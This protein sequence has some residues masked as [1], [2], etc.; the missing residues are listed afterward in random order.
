MHTI[1]L[2][3]I[4]CVLCGEKAPRTGA[5]QKYCPACS[6][7]KDLERKLLWAADHPVSQDVQ[8][9][10]SKKRLSVTKSR[11]LELSSGQSIGWGV[12]RDILWIVRLS[13]P[14]SYAMS[15]NHIYTNTR[16][17]HRALRSDSRAHRDRI[18]YMVKQ[19]LTGRRFVNNKVWIELLVQKP[20][21]K[22]DA[23]NVIDL[24]ADAIK[25][26]VGV[27]DRWFCIHKLDWEIVKEDPKIIIGIGQDS[28]ED[29]QP[30]SSCG[31][32]LPYN[33]FNKNKCNI[34]GI[35]RNCRECMTGKPVV[36]APVVVIEDSHIRETDR[37]R[38][39]FHAYRGK[40]TTA[41]VCKA[42]GLP[43]VEVAN[44]LSKG[45]DL[46][47]ALCERMRGDIGIGAP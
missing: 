41:A 5:M 27:D 34:V 11:G 20:N 24:V 22:G 29:V 4:T 36:V 12:E 44:W 13:V 26:A 40:R 6:I 43:Y 35:S 47:D 37:L 14:F 19:A 3:T 21:H 28:D 16:F 2:P 38:P 30:C 25:K 10:K 9:A 46:S 39:L 31:R 15:K 45:H 18:I 8:S 23:I 42:H 33:H 17:G 1:E 7:N 32:I